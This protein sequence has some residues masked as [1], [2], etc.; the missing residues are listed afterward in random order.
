[1]YLILSLLFQ[2]SLAQAVDFETVATITLDESDQSQVIEQNKN[3]LALEYDLAIGKMYDPTLKAS[4]F[5]Q[6]QGFYAN[7]K[8]DV[9]ILQRTPFWGAVFQFG[10]R[11]G[12]GSFPV[13]EGK[14]VTEDQGEFRLGLVLP[15]LKNG[16]IDQ[17]R[18]NVSKSSLSVDVA[19][20][21]EKTQKLEL[22]K[23]LSVRYW[24]WYLSGM[25]LKV[26][27]E[28][29]KLAE[30]RQSQIKSRVEKGDLPKI[31]QLEGDR[32]ILQ[33]TSQ[34]AQAERAFVK[35]KLDI[36]SFTSDLEQQKISDFNESDLPIYEPKKV[37]LQT[38]WKE[39]EASIADQ[40][41]EV[42][43]Q[44]TIFEQSVIDRDFAK[45]Q[46][47]PKLDLVLNS[48]QD[49]GNKVYSLDQRQ[50]EVG[51]VFEFPIPSRAATAKVSQMNAAQLKQEAQV[52]I[53]KTRVL[54]QIIDARNALG[55]SAERLNYSL[56]E[57]VLAKKLV[58]LENSRFLLGDS[59]LINLNIREQNLM[60]AEVRQFESFAEMK[61][62]EI[63][64]QVASG[65]L[66]WKNLNYE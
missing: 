27:Q 17:E 66:E 1:M 51:V 46:F 11:R 64:L 48:S 6:F 14:A 58:Q 29:L 4:Y 13:Y 24:D 30:N 55:I 56:Q 41:P 49:Y 35:F 52:S 53:S 40:H 57:A 33:R 2:T 5:N 36:L 8:M 42:L 45:N 23:Q 22:L 9:S 65:K 59:S 32:I 63:E 44:Q 47:L 54:N 60:E 31:D 38:I 12:D 37:N 25:R 34:K 3:S 19:K 61:K 10:F 43:R 39:S 26:S 28:I 15:L 18:A 7:R 16:W 62:S 21:Q 50:S 20:L